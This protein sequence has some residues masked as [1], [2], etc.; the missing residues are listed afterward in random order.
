M[1]VLFNWAE[2]VVYVIDPSM[3]PCTYLASFQRIQF[4]T[5]YYNHHD[6]SEQSKVPIVVL[7]TK[8]DLQDEKTD[9]NFSKIQ[10]RNMNG[11]GTYQVSALEPEPMRV[12]LENV[13]RDLK[14][15]IFQKIIRFF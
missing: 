11:F 2:L 10:A 1:D 12:A 3:E 4:L 13:Q 6:H 9:V 8:S 7:S 14:N 5:K 15:E